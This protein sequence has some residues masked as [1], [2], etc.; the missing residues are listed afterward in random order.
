M[1]V[2][3]IIIVS[4][5]TRDVL[6]Q[7][8]RSLHE[9]P[10]RVPHTTTVVDNAST[11][12]SVE[13]VRRDWPDVR[14]IEAGGNLG[15]AR[16]NNLGIRSTDGELVLLLNSDTVVP[17]GAIDRLVDRLRAT[18]EAAAVGPRLVDGA[19]RP[20]LSFGRMLGPLNE[21]VQ[22]VR[23]TALTRRLPLLGRVVERS[24]RRAAYHDW[25]SAACLLVRRA[26]A[27]AVGLLDE[28]YR[29]Y[30]EDVDFCAALRRRDRGVLFCPE[31]EV[32]HLRGRSRASDPGAARTFYRQS[33]L[34]FY[35]KHR[36]RWLPLLRLYLRLK[37]QLPRT[38]PERPGPSGL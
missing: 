13:T 14:L 35:A 37:G 3:D 9:P 21:L 32:V 33:Q 22:R 4:F 30:G 18:P 28:R 7:C 34:A 19:G 29:L 36:P 10:P 38:P 5:N 23:E 15:F 24:L 31:V 20:E 12:G 16:A 17:P 2:V 25:V 6:A 27:V 8:L 1:S 11:D 26:D